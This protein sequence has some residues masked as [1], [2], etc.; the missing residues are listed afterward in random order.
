MNLAS[1]TEQAIALLHDLIRKPSFSQQE[2]QTAG[3]LIDFL[4]KHDLSPNR[5]HH[6]IWLKNRHYSSDKPTLLLNSHHDTVRPAVGWQRNPFR[7]S[8]EGDRLYGL[9]SNDA[10]AS[11]VSLLAT[12]MHLQADPELPFNLL[13]VASAE[14]EISGPNGIAAVLPELGPIDAA[15]V[16]EPTGMQMAIAEKGLM[17]IDAEAKGVSGHAARDEGTNALYIALE[18]IQHIRQFTFD[19]VSPFLGASRATVTQIEAGSQHN[20]VPD[21]CRFVIDV[22]TN[23]WYSNR[24]AH[25]LLQAG[26]RSTLTPRSYRLNSSRID[27]NHPLVAAGLMLGRQTFGSPT[28]SDQAL[29]PF[30]SLKMGPGDSARSHTADEYITLTEIREAISCYAQLLQAISQLPRY[31]A[32]AK[33]ENKSL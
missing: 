29:M 8:L 19:R 24:E 22:R 27:P 31:D 16:G 1:S 11:L 13:F 20:V 10:G 5:L 4:R 18:D 15:L 28:L 26:V 6:N 33:N 14:E 3:I 9:G 23:E 21:R 17:V 7:P 25:V 2:E 32:Y 30:P 12:F